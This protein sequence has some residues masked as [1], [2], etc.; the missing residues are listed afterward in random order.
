MEKAHLK[1]V[2]AHPKVE[3]WPKDRPYGTQERYGSS[4][5]HFCQTM[6]IPPEKFQDLDKKAARDL[7]WQYVESF[8]GEAPAKASSHMA[9]LE[10]F[11]R[12]KDG[13]VLPLH[14]CLVEH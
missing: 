13:E 5:M 10:S 1:F 7:V 9:A 11:Y 6:N 3:A 4:L 12:Y 14:A 8:R 2:K